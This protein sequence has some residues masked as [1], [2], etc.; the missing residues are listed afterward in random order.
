[1]DPRAL[2]TGLRASRAFRTLRVVNE[3]ILGEGL[4]SRRVR[5]ARSEV[6]WLR[7]VLE[8][9]DGLANLHG[10]GEG[11]ITIVTTTSRAAELDEILE[12]L[13][14]DRLDTVAR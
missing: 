6:A 4:A 13:G 8:A 1:M 7:Y 11:A 10:D 14:V 5:V 9:H 12:E 2:L 3:P